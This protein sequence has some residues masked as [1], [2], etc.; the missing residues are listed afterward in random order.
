MA[1][2]FRRASLLLVLA[3]VA[4]GGGPTPPPAPA[5]PAT[6]AASAATPTTL[7]GGTPT[8]ATPATLAASPAARGSFPAPIAHVF[9][10]MMENTDWSAVKGNPDMPYVNRALL[11]AFAHAENYRVADHPSLPNYI[12]LEAGANLGL[13][14]GDDL[15]EKH[16]LATT[17][18]LTTELDR[19]GISWAYYAE[20]LPG[21]GKTCNLTDPGTP[22]SEDHNPFVYF[23]DVSGDPPSATNAYCTRHERPY[24][25]FA[26]AL[27]GGTV[28]Q[29]SFVVPNDYHQGEKQAPGSSCALCQADTWL[30]QQI[31]LIQA[32]AAFQ[33]G[34]AILIL[35][36]EGDACCHHPSGL[37][38]VSPYA[39]QGYGNTIAY[40]HTS[41]LRTVQ[42]IFGVTPL[43]RGAATATDL[44]DLFRPAP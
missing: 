3:L 16:H 8:P 43:L 38:V 31:P 10:V 28:A 12:T 17:A 27:A 9:V 2:W 39:K 44:R 15:P 33:D 5:S 1:R 26:P 19:A 6:P 21:D 4:C 42:E 14:N 25:D 22:Y 20:N 11:P 32:S 13:T 36:D 41:T 23:T 29:Y 37:I 24:T 30:S 40:S 34:G 18:H 35:W 7:P